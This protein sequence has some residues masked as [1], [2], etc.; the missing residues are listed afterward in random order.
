MSQPSGRIWFPGNPWPDGH[1]LKEV[2]L[3]GILS[4]ENHPWAEPGLHLHLC[5][6]SQ[7]YDAEMSEAERDAAYDG[8]SEEIDQGIDRSSWQSYIVWG[9]YHACRI[10]TN[11]GP[12]L[13]SNG[14]P[15][16]LAWL[17]GK[18]F[19]LDPIDPDAE[20]ID[21][22]SQ[23]FHC[24][25][26]GH[27]AVAGHDLR[28]KASG[29]PG[30]FDIN[31]TGK[32]ALAYGG[33][34]VYRYDFRAEARHVPFQGFMSPPWYDLVQEKKGLF[35]KTVTRQVDR[36]ETL[37]PQAREQ[38]LRDLAARHSSIPQDAFVFEARK[39]KDWLLLAL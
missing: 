19:A 20:F 9:N 18:H 4:G 17:D 26:L 8:E 7:D 12:R 6:R 16:D 36:R 22:D 29:A 1:A 10:E 28:F 38:A 11:V 34:E 31:W 32:V 2:E 25:I 33:D 23:A 35:G 5:V 15:F 24:Y 21:F 37:S 30:H 27:D 14:E 13:G 39:H 3:W